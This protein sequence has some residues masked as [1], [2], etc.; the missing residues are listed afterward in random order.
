MTSQLYFICYHTNYHYYKVILTY[1]EC[2][3][4]IFWCARDE[5]K[6]CSDD[7]TVYIY[8]PKQFPCLA[9]LS[10]HTDRNTSCNLNLNSRFTR[11]Q[12]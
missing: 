10:D 9:I 1:E 2:T 5:A 7:S 3:F 11:T 4:K 8:K 12:I 6:H